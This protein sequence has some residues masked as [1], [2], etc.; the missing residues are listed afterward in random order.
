LKE[1]IEDICYE[2][3]VHFKEE[4]E[5]LFPFLYEKLGDKDGLIKS[6]LGEHVQIKEL[7]RE[8]LMYIEHIKNKK[9]K[10][11]E[12]RN[13]I[14]ELLHHL[15]DHILKENFYLLKLAA[16]NLDKETLMKGYHIAERIREEYGLE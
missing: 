11:S 10:W 16:E 7:C 6:L 14:N 9:N 4:E 1:K 15:N 3:T 12:L 13:T 8:T 2:L 5:G